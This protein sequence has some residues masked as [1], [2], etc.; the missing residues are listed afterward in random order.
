[1]SGYPEPV[2]AIANDYFE[3]VKAQLR[4]LPVPEQDEFLKEIQSHVFEAYQQTPGETDVARILAVL[5]NL[6]EPAELV[7]DRL[8][9]AML[10]SGARRNL[11]FYILGG[12]FLALFGIPLGAGGVGVLVGLLAALAGLMVGYFAVAGSTLLVSALFILIGL[13]RLVAP[14]LWDTLRAAGIIQMNGPP[15]EFLDGFPPAYQGFLLMMIGGVL[16]VAGLSLLRVGKLA[17][18]GLGFLFAIFVDWVRRGA[19]A[20]RR[21]L[22]REPAPYPANQLRFVR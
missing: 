12:L 10:R 3:R 14:H 11:P 5:R 2:T 6:G 18:R 8:P 22:R 4:A 9:D 15:G 13:I 21:N 19:R 16:G 17:I 20:F 1:M 7:A